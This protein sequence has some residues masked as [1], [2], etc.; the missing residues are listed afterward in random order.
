MLLGGTFMKQKLKKNFPKL[1]YIFVLF[2]FILPIIFI[3]L[4]MIFGRTPQN[5]AGYHSQAD[6]ALMLVECVL[7][8]VVVHIPSFLE[9]K[10]KF[11]LPAVLYVL[12]ALKYIY[13]PTSL[14]SGA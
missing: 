14:T 6:Y 3:V 2:S 13:S 9:R 5:E 7:G 12:Y 10:L 1:L 8:L 4:M 11:E